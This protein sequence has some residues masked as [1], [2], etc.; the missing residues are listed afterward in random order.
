MMNKTNYNVESIT[1]MLVVSL[2]V[3]ASGGHMGRIWTKKYKYIL[4]IKG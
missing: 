1:N 2:S 4:V 3:I